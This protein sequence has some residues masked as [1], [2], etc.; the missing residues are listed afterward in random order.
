[1]PGAVRLL[2]AGPLTAK[3]F[4]PPAGVEDPVE[5]VKLRM[6]GPGDL[7]RGGTELIRGRA[8]G[9]ANA[10]FGTPEDAVTKIYTKTGDDGT[11]GL[12][13]GKRL[14]KDAL[15]IEAYGT[16]D[17]LNAVLGIV[18]S[19][20]LP[21]RTARILM[22]VQDDLFT[23]GAELALPD[24]ADRGPFGIPA[25]EDED[26]QALETEID[27]CEATLEPLRQF[28]LPGGSRAGALLHLART[29][30]RRAERRCVALA[31]AERVDPQVIRYLNR[32]SDLCF[33]LARYINHQADNRES[34]PTFGRRTHDS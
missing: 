27:E 7:A 31:H 29:V 30:A 20:S 5:T 2:E 6:I 26:I 10:D 22:R 28:I 3:V 13:G 9:A 23:I 11:T 14:P 4:H 33:V 24:G 15:R 12:I 16:I 25:I 17:E 8:G 34:H 21:E 32:L 1:L 19:F 18:A